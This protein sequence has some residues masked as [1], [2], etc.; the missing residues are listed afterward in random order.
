MEREEI[1]YIK[2]KAERDGYK[3]SLKDLY[4]EVLDIPTPLGYI[5]S[6]TGD[7]SILKYKPGDIVISKFNGQSP[8]NHVHVRL[9]HKYLKNLWNP[10]KMDFCVIMSCTRKKPY[11]SSITHKTMIHYLELIRNKYYVNIDL[12]SISEPMLIVPLRYEHLYPLANYDFPPK[13]MEKWEKDFMIKE[14]A[15][16]LPKIISSTKHKV[17]FILPKH[18]YK[19]VS[20][21]IEVINNASKEK[22]TM[23]PYGRLAFKTLRKVYEYILDI[24]KFKFIEA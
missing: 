22:I 12:F 9:Y 11:H 2:R 8:F 7:Y 5:L 1:M 10:S 21:A 17:I 18:H 19:I 13:L 3:I 14:I 24:I 4:D 23:Y 16:I 15:K 6:E 20:S